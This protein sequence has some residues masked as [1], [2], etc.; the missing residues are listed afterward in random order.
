MAERQVLEL[1]LQLPD[2][3]PV[4]ERREYRPG[5]ERQPLPL[6]EPRGIRRQVP[7]VAQG[8]ELLGEPRQDQPRIADDREQHLAQRLRLSVVETLGGRPVA[9]QAEVTELEEGDR[10][11]GRG[12]AR[13][14]GQAVGGATGLGLCGSRSQDRGLD[15]HGTGEV[16]I[17]R[18]RAQQ[19]R[20]LGR[21][22]EGAWR[23]RTQLLDP[24]PG[25]GDRG[26][27][28]GR[29]ELPGFHCCLNGL[30]C[31]YDNRRFPGRGRGRRGRIARRRN[32]RAS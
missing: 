14:R 13:D 9:R 16:G 26:D 20:R 30:F 25:G 32:D 28:L 27:Q 11:V 8:D 29:A 18:E 7:G 10:R 22:V 2:P 23:K 21:R 15:Q 4:R 17:G 3:E 31:G 19:L 5:L 6:G 12:P 24:A 1:P